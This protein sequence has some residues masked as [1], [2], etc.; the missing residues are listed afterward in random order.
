MWYSEV[1]LPEL[2]P[3][4]TG[5]YLELLHIQ[6]PIHTD[7]RLISLFCF[8]LS[9]SGLPRLSSCSRLSLNRTSH[10][11]VNLVYRERSEPIVGV[12]A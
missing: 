11:A 4:G 2:V 10:E 1:P 9:K 7:R 5:V 6:P 8:L 3:W 12:Q